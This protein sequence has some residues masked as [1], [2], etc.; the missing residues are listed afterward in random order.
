MLHVAG[1]RRQSGHHDGAGV[2][3]LNGLR[4]GQGK[5]GRSDRLQGEG[6][7]IHGRAGRCGPG[8]LV[9]GMD[10]L[11]DR[12]CLGIGRAGVVGGRIHPGLNGR[13]S[14]PSDESRMLPRC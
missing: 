5:A 3:N 11:V 7:R 9:G 4:V 8:R 10:I 14:P 12:Q 2:G 1:R 13:R 6:T